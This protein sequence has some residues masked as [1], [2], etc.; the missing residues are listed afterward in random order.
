[1]L[2]HG[3]PRQVQNDQR[4]KQKGVCTNKDQLSPV[5]ANITNQAQKN[6]DGKN[7]RR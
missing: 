6:Y 2:L 3:V 7:N 5:V 1:M 4:V